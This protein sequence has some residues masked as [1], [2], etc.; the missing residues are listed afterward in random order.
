MKIKIKD[1]YEIN[2]LNEKCKWL[3]I[4]SVDKD[5]YN[6]YFKNEIEFLYEN[7]EKI[8]RD[9]KNNINKMKF[10][11]ILNTKYH[12]NLKYQ[13]I[14][15]LKKVDIEEF[16]DY[17]DY[18]PFKILNKRKKRKIENIFKKFKNL[19][20]WEAYLYFERIRRRQ[21]VNLSIF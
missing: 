1:L 11:I 21:I 4:H 12:E 14:L 13:L 8:E 19:D 2:V 9:F 7:R 3:C 5:F 10:D 18:I 16:S 20:D 17:V 15:T 6:F